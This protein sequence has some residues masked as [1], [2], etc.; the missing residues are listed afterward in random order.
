MTATSPREAERA[1]VEKIALNSVTNESLCCCCPDNTQKMDG[2]TVPSP[3][4]RDEQKGGVL[5]DGFV[6][7]I[8]VVF[9]LFKC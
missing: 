8:K 9:I 7:C 1:P 4:I 2:S 3:Q 5:E 6:I